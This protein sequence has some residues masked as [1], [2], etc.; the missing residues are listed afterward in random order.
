MVYTAL[1][2]GERPREVICQTV[3]EP[4]GSLRPAIQGAS[5]TRIAEIQYWKRVTDGT[6]RYHH[7]F[8]VAA[9]PE[10]CTDGS[11]KL[12]IKRGRYVVTS[13]GIE[14]RKSGQIQS[15]RLPGRATMLTT[16]GPLDWI[17]VEAENGSR[18]KLSFSKGSPVEICHDQNGDL[19]IVY[20]SSVRENPRRGGQHS[21]R[22]EM[23]R[24]RASGRSRRARHNPT[25]RAASASQPQSLT[26]ALSMERVKA[27]L[28]SSVMLGGGAIVGGM[29]LNKL[30]EKVDA[31]NGIESA[32]VKAA[33]KVGLGVVGGLALG[34]AVPAIAPLAAGL[35]IGGVVTGGNEMIA[36]YRRTNPSLGS[37]ST[38]TIPASF[39]DEAARTAFL[40][41]NPNI[42]AS[43]RATVMA[44]PL[45]PAAGAYRANMAYMPA[46]GVELPAGYVTYDKAACAG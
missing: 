20:P 2:E 40:G 17:L 22:D 32:Y 6:Y 28:K 8:A 7:P 36:E 46:N 27:M 23:R 44:R 26:Q 41:Q 16:L 1:H 12:W 15:E 38:L 5:K 25:A 43:D 42:S 33:V 31:L 9:R 34:F 11:G 24:S 14:D 29:A 35:A 39:T 18:Q 13:R 45:T 19:H 30:F 37:G 10:I 21:R 4:N 3:G